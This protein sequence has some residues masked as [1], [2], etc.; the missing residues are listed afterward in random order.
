MN[1]ITKNYDY[2]V[3]GSGIAGLIYALQVSRW[4][5]VAVVTK[6][7]LFDCNTDYAQGGIAAVLDPQDSFEKHIEDTYQA[8]A[9]LGKKKVIQQVIMEGPKL[10]QYLI[11]LGTDFTRKDAAYDNCLENLSLTMEGG[12]TFRRIAYAEDST[13][14]QIMET[15]TRRCRENSNIDIYEYH[16][17]IDL[18]TQHHIVQDEGFTPGITCWGAYIMDEASKEVSIFR[19]RK[20]MLAT[21]GAARI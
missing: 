8:G 10:I 15:L 12:H 2:L 6:K 4:G 7:S 21:G 5:K 19:A 18:I 14:H 20:T 11:D 16:I 3:I 9:A 1:G 13:G 17:A